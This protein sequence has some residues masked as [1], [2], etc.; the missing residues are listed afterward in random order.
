MVIDEVSTLVDANLSA[1][2]QM[3]VM[4]KKS[5]AAL[6][7]DLQ[8]VIEKYSGM[9][10]SVEAGAVRDKSDGEVK[11]RYATDPKYHFVTLNADEKAE[12]AQRIAPVLDDWVAGLGAQGIDGA[13]LLARERELQ[14]AGD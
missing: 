4:N 8:A 1:S 12:I 3:L 14:Q 11:Q 13:K 9:K 6:P 2:M 5:Y 7:P 10:L